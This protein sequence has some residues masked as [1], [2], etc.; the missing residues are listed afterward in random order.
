[1]M[2][3]TMMI[4]IPLVGVTIFHIKST[5]SRTLFF[6]FLNHRNKPMWPRLIV[7]AWVDWLAAGVIMIETRLGSSLKNSRN[8]WPKDSCPAPIGWVP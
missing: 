2:M 3:T 7:G 6:S 4:T 5:R 1:M 8:D